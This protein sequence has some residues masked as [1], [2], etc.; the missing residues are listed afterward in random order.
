[1]VQS[2]RADGR[3]VALQGIGGG[4]HLAG[5]PMDREANLRRDVPSPFA[6]QDGGTYH[7]AQAAN[8]N[9]DCRLREIQVFGRLGQAPM[10]DDG[11]ELNRPG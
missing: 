9:A 6:H 5:I 1:M 7:I 8:L 10:L 4:E 3:Y 2:P 11:N